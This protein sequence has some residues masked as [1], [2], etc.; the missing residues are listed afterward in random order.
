VV[1]IYNAKVALSSFNLAA[2]RFASK[3]NV[4]AGAGSDSHVLQGLGTA[5]LHMPRFDDQVTFM[6]AL[7][8]ADI[9]AR[10]KN[11]LYLQSIKFLQT[12]LDRALTEE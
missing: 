12:T 5:M 4:V 8:E 1:E 11:L 7:S 6:A 9:V 3:Y 10:R 2:E